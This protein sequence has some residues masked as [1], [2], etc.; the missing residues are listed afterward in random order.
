MECLINPFF[1]TFILKIFANLTKIE[2]KLKTLIADLRGWLSSWDD[3]TFPSLFSTQIEP[4][5]V[6]LGFN[7][8]QLSDVS[9]LFRLY[10]THNREKPLGLC[11]IV[12]RDIGEVNLNSTIKGLHYAAEIIHA[13]KDEELSWGLLTDGKRWRIYHANEL[14]PYETYLEIDLER[15]LQNDK[16]T[17]EA[18]SL[19][20]LLFRRQAFT[21]N[22]NGQCAL[23]R[24]LHRSEDTAEGIE[25]HLSDCI[26]VI[27]RDLCQGFVERDGRETY[28]PNERDAIF[29]NAT[30]LLYRVLFILYAEARD[31]LPLG[32]PAYDPYSLDALVEKAI[33]YT[34]GQRVARP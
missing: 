2:K 14:A 11:Y 12:H 6:A 13:L 15:I 23:D 29:R 3:S 21:P 16:S 27:L 17:S 32:D 8:E 20:H 10:A 18:I 25:E 19:F 4:T 33:D 34:T 26:E 7:Y 9:N 5:L 24:H 31:L 22:D 30:V 1:L 28:T